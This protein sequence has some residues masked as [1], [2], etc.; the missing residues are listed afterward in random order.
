[1]PSR[2]KLQSGY[3]SCWVAGNIMFNPFYDFYCHEPNKG[4][5]LSNIQL[6]EFMYIIKTGG[7][8]VTMISFSQPGSMGSKVQ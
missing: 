3:S 7:M 5:L 2:A 1:M 4:E 8:C 6:Y